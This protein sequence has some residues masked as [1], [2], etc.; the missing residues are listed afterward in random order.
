M[1]GK[2]KCLR[3]GADNEAGSPNCTSCGA[4]LAEAAESPLPSPAS[5]PMLADD[6]RS[7]AELRAHY[8]AE[9]KQ[10]R[11]QV[12]QRMKAGDSDDAI[13]SVLVEAGMDREEAIRRV[14]AL[15][16]EVA[17]A[18]AHEQYGFGNLVGALVGGGAAAIIG[19]VLW[20]LIAYKTEHEIGYMAWG[21]GFLCGIGVLLLSGG[22]KGVPFQ[23]IA[24]LSS[25]L[26][27]GMGKY[28]TFFFAAKAAL[29]ERAGPV[30]AAKLSLFSPKAITYFL[31]HLGG[32]LSFFDIL[33][34]LFAVVT[35][36]RIPAALGFRRPGHA[37]PPPPVG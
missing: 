14:Q 9:A 30:T 23:V 5:A 7:R 26:G 24:V 21:I 6:A 1:P 18:A 3:C 8:E 36:W 37:A 32:M 15:D 13:V 2:T 11:S 33:W 19:G 4:L 34:V 20:G 35:A 16:A 28:A 29:A 27:I 22:R 25:I 17:T 10:S 12:L 31:T